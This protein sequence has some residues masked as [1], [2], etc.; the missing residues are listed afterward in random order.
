MK[1]PR[2]FGKRAA[3]HPDRAHYAKGKCLQCY[4]AWWKRGAKSEQTT[5]TRGGWP[6][7]KEAM[8]DPEP[9]HDSI[10]GDIRK[11]LKDV[12]EMLQMN[13]AARARLEELD[14][15]LVKLRDQER[16]PGK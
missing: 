14:R 2:M 9:T 7:R 4:Q 16:A 15:Q 10:R 12:D 8:T 5:P 13:K 3:C 11:L 1:G 6:R